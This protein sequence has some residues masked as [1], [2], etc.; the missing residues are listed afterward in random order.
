[1]FFYDEPI[2]FTRESWRGRI[3]A[4]RGIGATLSDEQ[5]ARFDADHRQLLERTTSKSF[6]ILHRI[7]C[8]VFEPLALPSPRSTG[9]KVSELA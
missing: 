8:H 4:C 6:T 7:D 1:M 2:A 9:E 3:R 5:V